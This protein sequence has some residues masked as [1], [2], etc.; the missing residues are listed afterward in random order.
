[1][2]LHCITA[3]PADWPAIIRM[4]A[5]VLVLK[6]V[7]HYLSGRFAFLD[8]AVVLVLAMASANTGTI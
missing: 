6:S 3:S 5:L 2:E 8:V 4:Q 7:T 1:M